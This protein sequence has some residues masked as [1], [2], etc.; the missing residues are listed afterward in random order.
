MGQAGKIPG[1]EHGKLTP[2]LE[3]H[4]EDAQKPFSFELFKAGGSNLTYRITDSKGDTWV[5]R[6]P[7]V[8]QQLETA[9]DMAR[10]WKV[11]TALGSTTVPTPR[12]FTFCENPEITGAVFYL[13]EDVQ[14]TILRTSS[15]ASELTRAQAD[16]ATTSLVATQATLH[17]IDVH[18]IDLH[19]F[20]RPISYA[21]RQLD[22]WH[23][24]IQQAD[25]SD[26]KVL[27]EIHAALM[28]TIPTERE[29]PT[30]IHGDFR[31]DNTVLGKDHSV[32]AVLDWEL[33]TIGNPVADFA[34]S[35]RYWADQGDHYHWLPDPPTLAPNFPNREKVTDLYISLTG[36]DLSEL[37]W[38]EVFSWWKFSCICAGVLTRRK[39]G[40]SAGAPSGTLEALANR[41]ANLTATAHSLALDIL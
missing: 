30:L 33:S 31:F 22:R 8:G 41:V 34:W 4:I 3:T 9:H 36:Y 19:D 18:A 16:K 26:L 40:I 29:D 20:S 1:I 39:A 37:P 24:Q 17:T 15:Q 6:R 28:A 14:G 23:R 12:C 25:F 21:Q 7:P 2:W 38:Y 11:L 35:L 32:I 13:M 10:E 5:L 27:D